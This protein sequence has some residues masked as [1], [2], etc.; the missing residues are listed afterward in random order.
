MLPEE[1]KYATLPD[2]IICCG[3]PKLPGQPGSSLRN[4]LRDMQEARQASLIECNIMA[5]PFLHE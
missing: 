3:V 4:Y 1:F 5:I 2:I